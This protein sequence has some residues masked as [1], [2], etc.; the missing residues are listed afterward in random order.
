MFGCRVDEAETGAKQG[1]VSWWDIL[2][3]GLLHSLNP[4]TLSRRPFLESQLSPT[5]GDIYTLMD[6]EVFDGIPTTEFIDDCP[7]ESNT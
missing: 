5:A 7:G 1:M 6:Q 2:C 4:T 3:A